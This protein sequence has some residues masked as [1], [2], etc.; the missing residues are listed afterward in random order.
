MTDDYQ[1]AQ[2]LAIILELLTFCI[3]HH[4]YNIKNYT[5]SKDLIRRVL[6]LLK[7]R[8]SFLA[9]G[10]YTG[11]FSVCCAQLLIA[12]ASLYCLYLSAALRLFRKVVGL[13][14]D[15]YNRYLIKNDL[16][17][18][19]I[20]AFVRNG[21]KYNLLNSAMIELFEFMKSVRAQCLDFSA[22]GLGHNA[23]FVLFCSGR[24][25]SSR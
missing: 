5:L 6:V 10:T 12:L 23:C 13:K 3:E 2:L 24:R 22:L 17:K 1:T 25:T 15:F 7:S 11:C 9:L 18:P 20:E 19:V 21:N 16:F 8:H 14:D 4:A